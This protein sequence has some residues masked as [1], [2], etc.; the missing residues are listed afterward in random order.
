MAKSNIYRVTA[1]DASGAH[2]H[3]ES[4]SRVARARKTARE[5]L[6]Y[7]NV[8]TVD[9]TNESATT[10]SGYIMERYVKLTSNTGIVVNGNGESRNIRF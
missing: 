10:V 3:G 6:R 1:F 2:I 5:F 8:F 7:A 4:T 9:V